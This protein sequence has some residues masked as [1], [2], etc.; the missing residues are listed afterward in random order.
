M[1]KLFYRSKAQYAILSTKF[2]FELLSKLRDF[3]YVYFLSVSLSSQRLFV[4][5]KVTQGQPIGEVV[6][7]LPYV[8]Y[9]YFHFKYDF[10]IS[11]FTMDGRTLIFVFQFLV[12]ALINF[13]V[14]N[15]DVRC[16]LPSL[17]K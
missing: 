14:V 13:K 16:K 9:M 3:C 8:Y 1:K 7:G 15:N 5:L 11:H 4:S 10:V 17:N 6:F 2:T 12:I